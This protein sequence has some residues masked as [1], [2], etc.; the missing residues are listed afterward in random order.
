VIA[1]VVA[2]LLCGSRSGRR[3]MSVPARIGAEAFWEFAAF[4]LNTLVFLSIGLTVKLPMLLEQWRPIVAAYVLVTLARVVVTSIVVAALPSRLS[5]PGRWTAILSWG[6][7]RGAL[8]M[9][10]ALS[11]PESHPQRDLLVTMTFGVVVLSI[12]V[13]GIT[14]GP[15]LRWLGLTERGRVYRGYEPTQAALLSAHSSLDDLERTGSMVAINDGMRRALGRDYDEQLDRAERDL[16]ALGHTL[17]TV[18]AAAL[19]AQ[20]LLLETERERIIEA[21]RAG[22]INDEQRNVR[23]A[24]LQARRWNDGTGE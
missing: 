9:V 3:G 21:H 11:I 8:S 18:D 15:A 5:L 1:T 16:S 7:L 19:A 20:R 23:L 24:D 14:V 10:L 4:A 22:A 2:G 17:G 6:G 12:L 13:Q